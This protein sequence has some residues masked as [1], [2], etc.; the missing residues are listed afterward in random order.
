MGTND[1]PFT[2]PLLINGNLVHG[3][4]HINKYTTYHKP[5]THIA[6]K[7]TIVTRFSTQASMNQPYILK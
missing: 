5:Y 3:T 6:Y 7:Y 4:L 2:N 1:A